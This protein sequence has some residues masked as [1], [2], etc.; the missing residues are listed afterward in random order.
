MS[1]AK[2]AIVQPDEGKRIRIFGGIEFT[3]KISS[4]ASGGA[5]SLLDNTNPAGTYLPPHVHTH[6]DETFYI[7]EGEFEFQVGGDT[8]RSGPGATVF[9]PRGVL[10]TGDGR[11][12]YSSSDSGTITRFD[13]AANTS[14]VVASGLNAPRH[15]TW[16][17]AGENCPVYECSPV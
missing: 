9:A 6:E 8:V 14:Q 12:A 7:L 10:I 1:A 15:L 2:P 16:A 13:L 3:V 4:H 17:D 5:L 11:F